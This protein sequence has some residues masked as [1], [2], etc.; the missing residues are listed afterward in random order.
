MIPSEGEQCG[1]NIIYL[2][3]IPYSPQLGPS[4][5][6]NWSYMGLYI[7]NHWIAWLSH[8][9]CVEKQTTFFQATAVMRW[10]GEF[11]VGRIRDLGLQGCSETVVFGDGLTIKRPGS[12]NLIHEAQRLPSDFAL[13]DPIYSEFGMPSDSVFW[14]SHGSV[15]E[16]QLRIN[17]A[18]F[19]LQALCHANR[20]EAD[21]KIRVQEDVADT[22]KA[23]QLCNCCS[24][25]RPETQF[26]PFNQRFDCPPTLLS[27]SDEVE[28]EG[29]LH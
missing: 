24:V 13:S 21:E 23:L 12:K 9:V 1:R 2:D 4:I 28:L 5:K 3:Y 6:W 27:R 26:Q 22:L 15:A 18:K 25:R 19:L 17:L 16:G 11:Q 8:H 7:P 14:W 29:L 10:H 20:R